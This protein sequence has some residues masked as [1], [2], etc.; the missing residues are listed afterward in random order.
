MVVAFATKSVGM[1]DPPFSSIHTL[2]IYPRI[3]GRLFKAKK[4][5][6]VTNRYDEPFNQKLSSR[7]CSVI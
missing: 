2:I 6:D 4:V 1:F 5:F 7:H 3:D